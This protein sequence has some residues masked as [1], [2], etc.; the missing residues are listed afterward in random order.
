MVPN[1]LMVP[2]VNAPTATAISNSAI[3]K[4]SER[5]KAS[6]MDKFKNMVENQLHF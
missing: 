1:D 6:T 5:L 3:A 4:Q 2:I